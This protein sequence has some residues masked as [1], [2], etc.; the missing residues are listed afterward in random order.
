MVDDQLDGRIARLA[1]IG[2]ARDFSAARFRRDLEAAV[3]EGVSRTDILC[4]LIVE[5]TGVSVAE[6]E[7]GALWEKANA[8]TRC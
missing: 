6:G 2:R 8:C 5:W 1:R 7:V 3:N 4:R